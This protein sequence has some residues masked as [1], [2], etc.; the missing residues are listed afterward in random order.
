MITLPLTK[1]VVVEQATAIVGV[2]KIADRPIAVS[3]LRIVSLLVDGR[4]VWHFA[5]DENRLQQ[6]VRTSPVSVEVH[7]SNSGLDDLLKDP[8]GRCVCFFADPFGD[9]HHR[10][11]NLRGANA[12]VV[13]K[14]QVGVKALIGH[15]S[16]P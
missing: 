12:N 15:R 14:D 1:Y 8:A 5:D 10:I 7:A 6:C 2:S 9:C 13:V 16:T 4:I 11:S 3:N